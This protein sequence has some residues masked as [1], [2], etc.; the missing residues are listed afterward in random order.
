MRVLLKP[1][2]IFAFKVF[3]HLGCLVPLGLMFYWG[4]ENQLS[5][6][7]V[8][9]LLH[10]TG[11]SAINLLFISLLI[12]PTAR[13]IKAPLL[14]RCRRLLGL[15]AFVFALCH[16][17]SY[18]IFELQFNW[19]LLV[20][21]VIKRP[22]ITVGFSAFVILILLA[23]TSLKWAKKRLGRKWQTLHNTVYIGVVLAITHYLWSVKTVYGQ[24][25]IYLVLLL[26][27]LALRRQKIMGLLFNR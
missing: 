22:Y 5:G 1:I 20:S 19:G 23:M 18:I 11:I 6:D 24:P 8:E 2:H 13:L 7:P 9:R 12:S 26:F 17:V 21:E 25:L 10:F 15:Y 14:M 4:I 16:F 27:I 3:V